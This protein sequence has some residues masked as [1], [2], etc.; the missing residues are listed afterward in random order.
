MLSTISS[1]D[2]EKISER[3]SARIRESENFIF[4]IELFLMRF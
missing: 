1:I 4:I 3:Y 2:F